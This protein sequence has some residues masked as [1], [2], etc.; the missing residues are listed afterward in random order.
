MLLTPFLLG[1]AVLL[2][3][4]MLLTTVLAFTN[5]NAF[6]PP[7]WNGL[8]NFLTIF[9]REL[10]WI[11]VRNS[12]VYTSFS[13]PLQLLGALLLALLL[14]H[15]R[16][17]VREYRIAAFLPSVI[18]EVAYA[19]IWLWIFNPLYGPLNK[20]LGWVGLPEQAWLVNTATALPSL[21]F[22]SCFRLGEGMFVL[23]AALQG[24]PPA[25]FHA[26]ALDGGSRWQILRHITLPLLTPWLLLLFLRD[27][28]LSTQS[29][30]APVYMMTEGG[31]G[32]ATMLLP[33][34][35]YDEAFTHFRLGSAAAM[36]L[37]MF[38][39]LGIILWLLYQLLGG[40]GYTDEI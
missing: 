25:Y 14:Y 13:V 4:P 9:Q 15:Q 26:A 18:P 34:L 12:L 32:Y 20:L 22:M 29:S 7:Q 39:A 16:Y 24:I 2:I 17:G 10:F 5:Y 27:I 21:I 28:L 38:V 40:W 37:L 6:A 19:L 8:Q 30:F 36:L 33:Y 35:I 3:L 31:P 11:A 23:I 1:T